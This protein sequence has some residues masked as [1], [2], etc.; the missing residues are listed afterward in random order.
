MKLILGLEYINKVINKIEKK[1]ET[2]WPKIALFSKECILT[3]VKIVA[4]S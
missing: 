2:Y 4:K 3:Q 1:G